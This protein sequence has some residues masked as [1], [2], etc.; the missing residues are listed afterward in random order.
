[1]NSACS[2]GGGEWLNG[3]LYR[4][5]RGVGQISRVEWWHARL[6]EDA[7]GEGRAITSTSTS[8]RGVGELEGAGSILLDVV[9]LTFLPEKLAG[10]P[11]TSSFDGVPLSNASTLDGSQSNKA[12]FRG[13]ASTFTHPPRQRGW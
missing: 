2:C 3:V 7:R 13:R 6:V 9:C 8:A 10:V 1:M 11:C 4:R 12:I 5:G